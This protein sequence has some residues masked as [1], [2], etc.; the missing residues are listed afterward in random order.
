[1]DSRRE[2]KPDIGLSHLDDNVASQKSVPALPPKLGP[3]SRV[4]RLRSWIWRHE[5]DVYVG[6]QHGTV[7]LSA[8]QRVHQ[9]RQFKLINFVKIVGIA[10]QKYIDV[11]GI[12]LFCEEA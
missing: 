8:V 10:P 9:R 6:I 1:M 3:I 11:S 2:S 5:P 7:L 4:V 12:D